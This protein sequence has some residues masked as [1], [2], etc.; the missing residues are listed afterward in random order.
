MFDIQGAFPKNGIPTFRV[1]K[2]KKVVLFLTQNYHQDGCVKWW[3]KSSMVIIP[4]VQSQCVKSFKAK[5]VVKFGG[6]G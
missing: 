3:A 6:P 4:E 2:C 1:Q 5:K